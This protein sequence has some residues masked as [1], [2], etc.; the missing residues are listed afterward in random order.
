MSYQLLDL[1]GDGTR[2]S[3][4]ELLREQPRSV[5]SLAE[6]L[7]VSRPA[8]SKHLKLMLEAGLVG[9]TQQGTRRIY[10]IRPEGFGAIVRYWDG[11]WT[12][13]LDEFKRHADTRG[14]THGSRY[15]SGGS[16]GSRGRA[17][18]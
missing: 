15:E 13:V 12:G 6:E 7:P 17:Q 1:V 10:R 8:V 16:Q 9:V 3:I 14:A 2:R 5:V 4:L 11:F 18:S